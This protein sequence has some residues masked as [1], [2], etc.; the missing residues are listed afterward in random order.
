MVGRGSLGADCRNLGRVEAGD[1]ADLLA[2]VRAWE[3]V[4]RLDAGFGQTGQPSRGFRWYVQQVWQRLRERLVAAVAGERTVLLLHH[5][6]LVG[7]YA[8]LGGREFL[9]SLQQAARSASAKPHGLWVLC[10]G[11]SAREAP[12]LDG[13]RVEALTESERV[14]LDKDFLRDL[15]VVD[16]AS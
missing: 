12:Q 9:T 11:E 2:K 7:R 8:D 16:Q 5:A 3:L 6:G 10:P 1:L 14:V 4:R 15:Q 13:L